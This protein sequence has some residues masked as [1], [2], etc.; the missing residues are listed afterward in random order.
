MSLKIRTK[1]LLLLAVVVAVMAL[2]IATMYA[3]TSSVTARLADTDAM[4]SAF[5]QAE[6]ID[7]FFT[8]L[9]NIPNNASPGIIAYL[10]EDKTFDADA[11]HGHL[12]KL[13]AANSGRGL[14]DMY[15]GLEYNGSI[16]SAS[17]WK[18]PDDYD[19]R[20]R[21]WYRLA[22]AAGKAVT[23]RPYVDADTQLVV[24]TAASPM[25]DEKRQ[26]IGVIGVDIELESLAEKIR[27]TNVFGGGYGILLD[28][29]GT[30]LE[31]PEKS[32]LIKENLSK[33]SE[34][35]NGDLAALGRK[36]VARESG[37][38]DYNML[39]TN[40][41]IY[42]VPCEESGFISVVICPKE[43]LSGI[44]RSVTMP[45][46]VAGGTA[47]VLIFAYMLFMIPSITRPIKVVQAALERMASLNLTSDPEL[48]KIVE[49][50]SPGTELG[51]M[52]ESLRL[53]RTALIDVVNSLREG[54]DKL[55]NSSGTLENLSRTASAEVEGAAASAANVDSLA[56]DALRSVG[57]TADA[58]QEVTHAAT[59]TAVSA[60]EGAEASNTTS[61]LS[62]SV[63]EMVNGFVVELQSV[64]ES[65]I[66][67][68]EGM[69]EV[70]TSVAAIAEFVTSIRNIASQTNLLALNAAIEA[71]RAGESGRGFAVVADEVRKLAE[72]SHVASRRV[73]E[74]MEHLENGTNNAI[75]S[76]QESA[77]VISGIIAKAQETQNRLK[78][79]IHEIDKVN[80]S[81]QTIAAAAEE[82]AASSNE[83]A[84]ATNQ[85]HENIESVANEMSSIT[86]ATSKTAA[87][88]QQVAGEAGNL[89][90]ISSNIESLIAQF[91]TAGPEDTKTAKRR[92]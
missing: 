58:V 13:M 41:R 54:V 71:A 83:I 59:M 5:Y 78:E 38:G 25:Y 11:L 22:A 46:I 24:V 77:G 57:A 79:A 84:E 82:Q 69:T 1:L 3:R 48:A 43:H 32:F 42:Y 9:Q 73:A 40:K 26:L 10:G 14:I 37:F 72:E 64:G 52:I 56:Q 17:T 6:L 28:V 90:D 63:S 51:A 68:S 61:Q 4:S 44:V 62:A 8:A 81:V 85:V 70:G 91:V 34:K 45:Q 2:L 18:A 66:K 50:I 86:R 65:S 76:T 19:S 7:I 53:V 36:I 88:I 80:D 55:V 23:T 20:T 47:I 35:V 31:H 29:D 33:T 49:K 21:D 12:E 30:V 15:V 89:S 67:N 60:T 87:S 27:K 75:R 74:M 92:P 16:T 39:G